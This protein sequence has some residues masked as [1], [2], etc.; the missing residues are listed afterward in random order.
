MVGTWKRGGI[1]LLLL[2]A[3][4]DALPTPKLSW[5]FRRPDLVGRAP[6]SNGLPQTYLRGG[7]TSVQQAAST[8]RS[9]VALFTRYIRHWTS[10]AGLLA[11]L[12]YAFPHLPQDFSSCWYEPCRAFAHME[13]SGPSQFTSLAIALTCLFVYTYTGTGLLWAHFWC[14]LPLSVW[15]CPNA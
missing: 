2:L 14:Q 4:A 11:S 10:A 8:T 1:W 9:S 7:S 5:P 6:H 12:C 13:S 3:S 15:P